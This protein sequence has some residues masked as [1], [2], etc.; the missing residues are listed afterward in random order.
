VLDEVVAASE[1]RE[2][3]STHFVCGL[4]ASSIDLIGDIELIVVVG[5]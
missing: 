3:F 5:V 4:G 1:T 2:V